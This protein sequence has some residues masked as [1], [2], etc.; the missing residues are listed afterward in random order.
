MD[1]SVSLISNNS[2]SINSALSDYIDP[3][4]FVQGDTIKDLADPMNQV[5]MGTM[6]IVGD[7]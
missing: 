1:N 2:E 4:S 6:K 3:R 7:P 5:T